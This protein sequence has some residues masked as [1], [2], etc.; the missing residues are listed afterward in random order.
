MIKNLTAK[1]IML[2]D[3]T[4]IEPSDLVAVAK[5]K[6][7]RANVG[8]VPVLDG[9]KLVGLITHRDVLLALSTLADFVGVAR[10][11]PHLGLNDFCRLVHNG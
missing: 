8:G 7:L 1:D 5:L 6:M 3:V 4:F 2:C 9:K 10:S 11:A